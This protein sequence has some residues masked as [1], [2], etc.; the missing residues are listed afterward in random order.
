M[1]TNNHNYSY[2]NWCNNLNITWM[3]EPIAVKL[4]TYVMPPDTISTLYSMNPS[5]HCYQHYIL[6]VYQKPI[7]VAARSKAWTV[8]PRSNAGFV[9]SNPTQGMYVYVCLFCVCVLSCVQVEALRWTDPPAKESYRLCKR[10]RN[11]KSGQGPI[12]GCRGIDR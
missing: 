2:I 11:W 9:G 5:H 4:G 10:S 1:N 6:R 7:T 12:K 8:F 3:P